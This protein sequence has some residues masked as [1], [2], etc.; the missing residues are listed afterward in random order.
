M[1]KYV[2][3]KVIGGKIH[4]TPGQGIPC[5]DSVN[6]VDVITVNPGATSELLREQQVLQYQVEDIAAVPDFTMT[7]PNSSGAKARTAT[8]VVEKSADRKQIFSLQLELTTERLAFLYFLTWSRQLQFGPDKI[9]INIPDE[10]QAPLENGQQPKKRILWD[11]TIGSKKM[12]IIPSGSFA[13]TNV[14]EMR[15][16]GRAVMELSE[17]PLFGPMIKSFNVLEDVMMSYDVTKRKR[18]MYSRVGWQKQ[19]AEIAENN[20]KKA[21]QAKVAEIQF[22]KA[23]LE[24][25]GI[26]EVNKIRAKGEVDLALQMAKMKLEKEGE[27]KDDKGKEKNEKA[28]S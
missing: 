22:E 19:M 15:M 23:K 14:Q 4:F 7:D 11:K 8:E 24:Q 5:K 6:D 9:E 20:A 21:Q 10:A 1:L 25:Q 3:D 2:D 17:K 27:K 16:I 28:K 18:W 13:N 26:N 12:T